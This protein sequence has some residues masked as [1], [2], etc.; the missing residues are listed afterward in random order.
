MRY[1]RC[2]CCDGGSYDD[3]GGGDGGGDD[4]PKE[5]TQRQNETD[6]EFF[7]RSQAYKQQRNSSNGTSSDRFLGTGN[8]DSCYTS[9]VNYKAAYFIDLKRDVQSS[10]VNYAGTLLS[11]LTGDYRLRTADFNGDG[12]TDLWHMTDGGVAIYTLNANNQLVLLHS[13]TNTNVNASTPY[14]IGDYNGD[15]KADVIIPTANNSTTF[16]VYISTGKDFEVFE[17][18]MPFTYKQTNWY[19]N[20]NNGQ[21]LGYTLIPLDINGDG[22]TDIVEYNT[23]TF[24]NNTNGNQQVKV[25]ANQAASGTNITFDYQ[26]GAG[27]TGNARHFPIPIFLSSNEPNRNLEFATISDQWITNFSFTQDVREDVLLRAVTNNGVKLSVEYSNLIDNMYNEDNML[28]Y[29]STIDQTYPYV[30]IKNAPGMKVVS[31]LKREGVSWTVPTTK[32]LY[33][34]KDAIFNVQGLGFLGFKAMAVSNWHSSHSN[35]VFNTSKY[36]PLLRGAQLESYSQLYDYSFTTPT[37]SYIA[38]TI[39]QYDHSLSANKVFKLWMTS[40]TSY[41]NLEGTST[42]ASYQYDTYNNPT[43]VTTTNQA[44][45]SSQTITYSNNSGLDYHFGRPVQVLSSS[46]IGSETF[47]SEEQFVFTGYLLTEKKIKGN[48]TPFDTENYEYDPFGNLTKKIITPNGE[49]PREIAFEYDASGRFLLKSIDHEGLEKTFGYSSNGTLSAV[50]NPFGQQTN[51]KYDDWFRQIEVTNYLGNKVNTSYDESSFFYTVTNSSDDGSEVK[52][53]FDP[54]GRLIRTEEKN[55]IGE[56]VKTKYEYDALDRMIRQSEPYL[57]SSPTQWNDVIYDVYGR[58]TEQIL[59]TG[60]TITIAYNGLSVTVDDGVKTVTTTK[61]DL[62]NLLSV[63]DP[64]GTINY[65]YYGNGNLKTTNYDGVIVTTE[66]DGWGRKTKLIDPSAGTYEYSYNG[67]GQ[68]LEE[69][70]P[71][72]T[73]EYDYSQTGRMLEKIIDGDN[74]SMDIQYVYDPTYNLLTAV[75]VTSSDGNNSQYQYEYDSHYRLNKV[76]ESNPYAQFRQ[77]FTYDNFGRIDSEL[78]YGRLLLNN[79]TSQKKIRNHYQNGVLNTITDFNSNANIWSLNEV[80][81]RGQVTSASLGNNIADATT[82]DAYGYLTNVSI[83]KNSTSEIVMQ[84]TTDFDVERGTL[85][86]RTNS[87]F[88]WSET[89]GYDD[90]DRLITFNDNN[91]DNFMTYDNSGRIT[92]NNIVG[93]YSYSGTSYQ[94]S[95]IDLNNQGDLYYQQNRLAQIKYNSFKKPFEIYEE[96]KEKIGFQYNP[97]LGRSNMFYGS[98]EDDINQRNNRKH[99]AFDGSMEISYDEQADQT[100]FVTYIG[101][102]AYSAPAIWRSEQTSSGV[103]DENYYYLHR[104]YLGSIVLIT[105]GEGNAKEKRHFDAWGNIVKLTDGNNN[106]LDKLSFLDRGYTGHEHLQ[107]VGL[108]HMNG[109]LYDP[110][111]KRFL[112]PDNYI[113]DI[114]NTQNFNRY[115]YVLNNPLM[116]TDPSGEL[117]EIGTGLAIGIGAVVSSI[118]ATDFGELGDALRNLSLRDITQGIRN[119]QPG[120]WLKGIFKSRSKRRQFNNYEGLSSD[121]LMG[122]STSVSTGMFG[123]GGMTNGGLGTSGGGFLDWAERQLMKGKLFQMGL[124]HGAIRGVKSSWEFIK[125]LGTA[126]GWVQMGQ[127]FVDLAHISNQYSPKGMYLRWQISQAII[128][129][130]ERIPSMSA[131]EI[132][133]DLGFAGE[134]VLETVLISR[135]TNLVVKGVKAT[136]YAARAGTNAYSKYGFQALNHIDDVKG[137]SG[138]YLFDDATRGMLPYVGK[139]N[140]SIA[141]RLTSHYN[142]GRIGGQIY[143]KPMTG[144]RTFLEVQETIMMNNLGGKLGTAN[145]VFP[146]SPA[147]N[148][149]L[150]LGITNY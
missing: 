145:R 58:P 14:L 37:S 129:Y 47:T 59:H 36:D 24:N 68:L 51:Y 12:K 120:R 102:D 123:G 79:K 1:C 63:S 112:A 131:Y 65:S 98:L 88:S 110:K 10:F 45:S 78:Y 114:T 139:S 26:G 35:R 55:V 80:N 147:R 109:R 90:L 21:L 140:V 69:I 22:K 108:I 50:T 96:D 60:R 122:P 86:S 95:D 76:I 3:G 27:K 143:F 106:S 94:V 93:D 124:Q 136:T 150:N 17:R 148:L 111:L 8:C 46:T 84:L 43:I 16:K 32:Q 121:P 25:Y 18:T 92:H 97:F 28:I 77:E 115:G 117:I 125:S 132:G 91:G 83:S 118:F 107:G 75:G 49:S 42:S 71:K 40:R 82:Y 57:G 144:S 66:Q 53:I 19:A 5:F 113:Q 81:A 44:G 33:I 133:N 100:L 72:G 128:N 48:G 74:L 89:F 141:S 31:M 39:N 6:E 85:N 4:K 116:Y 149:R 146:V 135:G 126:K 38:K 99:Y 11:S 101:G 62:G 61:D 73:T 104:D 119:L 2:D 127:G 13:L 56:W 103:T 142:A 23:T 9:T 137:V 7:A 29:Q 34:Y 67:F 134:Q 20:S 54:L 15:G 52:S 30:N 105:D 41:N 130:V 87:M 70:T 138:L 64:G